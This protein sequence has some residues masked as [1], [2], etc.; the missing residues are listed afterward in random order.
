M[1]KGIELVVDGYDRYEIR[2][3]MEKEY[4]L[5]F[6]RRESQGNVLNTLAKLAPVFG[7]VGTIIGLINVLANMGEPAEIGK[8][9]A[10]ALLTTFYGL[11]FANF[12]FLPLSKK[13]SE[14]TKNEATLL[15]V[16]M[17]GIVDI[18]EE[19]NSKS[20]SHRLQSY[21]AMNHLVRADGV[22][23][24]LSEEEVSTHLPLQRFIARKQSA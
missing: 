9:M 21:L 23:P 12:L 5:Y 19:K 20:I 16:I 15:N 3:I 4:D 10:L 1:R 8:G 17:E 24:S 7:F 6:S 11:L 22:A 13:L 14:H 2:T 18:S